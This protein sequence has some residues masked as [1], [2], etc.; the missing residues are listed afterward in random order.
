MKKPLF[1]L[2]NKP[3]YKNDVLYWEDSVTLNWVEHKVHHVG[4]L[5]SVWNCDENKVGEDNGWL[6]QSDLRT[7]KPTPTIKKSGWVYIYTYADVDCGIPMICATIYDTEELAKT[8]SDRAEGNCRLFGFD[9]FV[10]LGI[11]EVKWEQK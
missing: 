6:P 3:V 8:A 10:L 5:G 1:F 7:E 2:N 11:N 9:N 4:A